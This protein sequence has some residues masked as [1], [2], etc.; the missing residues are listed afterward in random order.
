MKKFYILIPCYNDW[1]S[2]FKLIDNIDNEVKKLNGEFSIL[3]VNDG[4][5]EKM[6]E[7]KKSYKNI[8]SI[9]VINMKKNQGHTR[10]NATGIRYLSE[11][12]DFDYMLLMDGDGEDRP[13]E[14]KLLVNKILNNQNTSVVAKRIK[15]SEGIIFSILYNLHKFIALIFTG[16]NMNFG[17][18]TCLTRNDVV[19][20]SGEKSL[21][22][23]YSGTLKKTIKKLDSIPCIRGNRYVQP[24]KMS[25]ANLIIHS[26]SILAI[27]KYR[28][29]IRSTLF[30]LILILAF[31]NPTVIF[32]QFM[33]ITFTLIVFVISRRESQ[34]G[35][36]NCM[37][38]IDSVIDIN[39]NR[40]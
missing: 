38:E 39:T 27:F 23:N 18:Y 8:K 24:S 6:E 34:S 1:H 21:W 5:T 10:S 33:L 20:I 9:Q 26:F 35:L 31:T 7:I 22:C 25:F 13:E 15:R 36:D 14:I 28:V 37:N 40:L 3:V 4:S 11:K 12:I 16:E 30:F 17:H 19:K 29:L 2:L 32:L